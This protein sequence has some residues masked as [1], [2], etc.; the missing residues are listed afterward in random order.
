IRDIVRQR[1]EAAGLCDVENF[2]RSWHILM[3]GSIISAAEG[4]VEAAQRAKAMARML[5]ERHRNS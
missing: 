3:K 2:A 4:D 1:A 5:I